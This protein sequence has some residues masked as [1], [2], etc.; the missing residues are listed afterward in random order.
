MAPS[1]VMHAYECKIHQFN[2]TFEKHSLYYANKIGYQSSD[3]YFLYYACF[4]WLL[5]NSIIETMLLR[6]F[7]NFIIFPQFFE[8]SLRFWFNFRKSATIK[9]CVDGVDS[10]FSCSSSQLM[11]LVTSL[12]VSHQVYFT[13]PREYVRI[14]ALFET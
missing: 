13:A 10:E 5:I 7:N 2:K 12:L 14:Y 6:M 4:N 1:F 11:Y 8:C 3:F 9:R